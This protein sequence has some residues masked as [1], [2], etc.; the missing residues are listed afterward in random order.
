MEAATG[1]GWAGRAEP[2]GSREVRNT[3][4]AFPRSTRACFCASLISL[5]GP[6]LSVC[7]VGLYSPGWPT[8]WL[9]KE[10]QTKGPRERRT[11]LYQLSGNEEGKIKKQPLRQENRGQCLRPETEPGAPL[12]HESSP[13]TPNQQQPSASRTLALSAFPGGINAR[14][15]RLLALQL[16]AHRDAGCLPAYLVTLGPAPR[17][18]LTPQVR[19]PSRHPMQA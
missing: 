16:Q 5:C 15:S 9:G 2:L 18:V 8:A 6:R 17:S 7:K 1:Q 3:G 19:R 10:V 13:E 12:Q 14:S 4:P 11:R